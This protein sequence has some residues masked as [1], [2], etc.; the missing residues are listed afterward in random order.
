M[1][2]RMASLFFLVLVGALCASG[3]DDDP[4]APGIEPEIINSPESFEF[5]V[6]QVRN[7]S[8]TLEYTWSNAEAAANVDESASASGGT[9]QLTV[10]DATGTVV[11]DAPLTDGSMATET[12]TAGNWTVRVRFS[13][14]SGTFNFRLQPRTP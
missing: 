10:L 1:T 7:Y 4:A 6:S 5:Q 2:T 13:R 11:H 3:C 9:V 8:G 12:G 14:A